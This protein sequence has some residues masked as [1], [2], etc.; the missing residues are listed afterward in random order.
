MGG[1]GGRWKLGWGG[2]QGRGWFG[3]GVVGGVGLATN[4]KL[5][6]ITDCLEG[7]QNSGTHVCRG[8]H[9]VTDLDK[10]P[11]RVSK[12]EFDVHCWQGFSTVLRPVKTGGCAP[13]RF[14]YSS[15]SF[16][17]F[18]IWRISARRDLNCQNSTKSLNL[19]KGFVLSRK[20]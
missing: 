3:G 2:R 13:F 17:S 15:S 1:G 7:N 19:S 14:K 16:S 9:R 10:F 12:D 6:N 11:V 5:R 20:I 4:V 8:V 18:V